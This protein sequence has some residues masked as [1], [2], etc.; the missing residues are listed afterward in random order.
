MQSCAYVSVFVWRKE[1]KDKKE[2]DREREKL[3]IYVDGHIQYTS[4][5]F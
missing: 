4:M 5:C 1:G 2:R 3:E